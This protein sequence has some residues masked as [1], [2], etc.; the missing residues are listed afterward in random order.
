MHWAHTE[1]NELGFQVQAGPGWG[2]DFVATRDGR[3]FAVRAQLSGS[4]TV[5]RLLELEGGRRYLDCQQALILST[6]PLSGEASQVAAKLEILTE[7]VKLSADRLWPWLE[8]QRGDVPE[9]LL[10]EVLD[11]VLQGETLTREQLNDLAGTRASSSLIALLTQLPDV[12]FGGYPAGLRLQ[13]QESDV[14]VSLRE[15]GYQGFRSVRELAQDCSEIPLEPGCYALEWVGGEPDFVVRGSGGFSKGDPNVPVSVLR[16][17]WTTGATILYVGKA[18][19]AG[20]KATLRSK[21][22]QLLEFG[23]GKPAKHYGGRYLWQLRQAP[24]LL[25]AWK[26]GD[27]GALEQETLSAFVAQYGRLPFAN[28]QE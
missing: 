26:V 6:S 4:P 2:A 8:G 24:D 20:T 17:Q 5:A 9:E 18:G 23:Q 3:T 13:V 15:L 21:V 10:R 28:L 27:P 12:E 11:R 14:Q 1:L 25:V 7:Q 16:S 22:K 19:A